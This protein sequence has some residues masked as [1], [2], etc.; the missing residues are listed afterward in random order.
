MVARKNPEL[1]GTLKLP[2]GRDG[3]FNEI[4]PKLRPVETVVDG[5]LIAGTCQAPKTVAE[6]AAS[7]LAAV[8]QAAAV[9]KRGVAE[10]DPQ[11][12]VVNPSACTGCGVCVDACPFGAITLV[13]ADGAAVETEPALRTAVIDGAGCKGCGGCAPVCTVDAID[14]RGYTD[15]Q[16]RA[17]IDGLLVGAAR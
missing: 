11:V 4:H 6:S 8:T 1:I 13:G 2:I 15:A 16:V 10:L 14:L 9:L 12:A 5:V 3:F 17:M 7:G